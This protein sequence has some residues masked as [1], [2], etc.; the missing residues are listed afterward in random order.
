M[1]SKCFPA[2]IVLLIFALFYFPTIVE[3]QRIKLS[4]KN[5]IQIIKI[6]LSER[7]FDPENYRT[8][9]NQILFSKANIPPSFQKNFPKKLDGYRTRLLS[10]KEIYPGFV[11]VYHIFYKFKVRGNS[12]LV[13]VYRR[14]KNSE[15]GAGYK[16]SK[17]KGRWKSKLV[18]LYGKDID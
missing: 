8:E 18:V 13:D 9:E 4:E 15:Y 10:R 2:Q 1:K 5:K 12:V 11:F 14:S 16:F 7:T 17:K 6:I 3:A